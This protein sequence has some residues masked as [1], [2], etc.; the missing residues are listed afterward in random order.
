MDGLV[1]ELRPGTWRC[2][3]LY[4]MYWTLCRAS[5]LYWHARPRQEFEGNGKLCPTVAGTQKLKWVC[6]F[7]MVVKL[8]PENHNHACLAPRR[9]ADLVVSHATL[10]NG[11][12]RSCNFGAPFHFHRS[13]I[14][15]ANRTF[16]HRT[17]SHSIAES[18]IR[19][20]F[21][22]RA[23]R[24]GS[25]HAATP[26]SVAGSAIDIVDRPIDDKAIFIDIPRASP[27]A[28]D[29]RGD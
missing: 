18:G 17:I 2:G 3:S 8:Q 22:H 14:R 10:S 28:R 13:I 24:R 9:W 12:R 4:A 6:S 23:L 16:G 15:S 5:I 19:R 7:N 21:R 26:L 1:R 25:I 20:S 27:T 29:R 11:A